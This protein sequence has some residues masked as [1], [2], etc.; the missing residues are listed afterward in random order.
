MALVTHLN[1]SSKAWRALD[2][3]PGAAAVPVARS[4]VVRAAKKA[5]RLCSSFGATRAVSAC[6]VHSQRALV[7]NDAQL[8]QLW[9]ATPQRG[10]FAAASTGIAILLPQRA[11]RKTSCMPI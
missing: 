2:G 5:H 9:T 10:H 7:S 3:P 4:M 1:K 8:M 11:Q 6:C